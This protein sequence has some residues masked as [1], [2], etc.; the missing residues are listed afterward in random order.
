M[1]NI[2]TEGYLKITDRVKD[3]IKTGGE[4]VSSLELEDIAS[5]HPAVS[6]AAA[7][8]VPD[9]KWGERP[10]LLVVLKDEYKEQDLEAEIKQSFVDQHEQG[11]LPKYGI[12]DKI[13]F[14][15]TIAKT[16]VGKLD[17]KV[18]RSQYK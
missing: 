14:V 18:I 17:K 8:G 13:F 1:G 6:E 11:N 10:I 15:D 7:I 2:D 12:P 3:V 9:E 5:R 16:G 4:W